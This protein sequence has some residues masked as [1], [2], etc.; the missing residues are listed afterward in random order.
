[1]NITAKEILTALSFSTIKSEGCIMPCNTYLIYATWTSPIMHL[2]CPPPPP[3]FCI[4]F[5][6]HFSWVLLP[7]QENLKTMFMQNFGGQIWCIMMGDVQVA[8][9][10]EQPLSEVQKLSPLKRRGYEL[11][12]CCE[13]EFYLHESK[14]RFLISGFAL[15]LALKMGMTYLCL[16]LKAHV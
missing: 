13:N 12:L 6:F 14:N 3:Q 7:S 8:Y 11:N 1:M 15:S 5:V 2:F 4:T 9:S 16:R 10:A